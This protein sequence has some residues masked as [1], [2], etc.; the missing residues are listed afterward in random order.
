MTNSKPDFSIV[1]PTFNRA[2]FL[3]VAISSVLKQRNI[4][5]EIIIGDNASTDKTYDIVK[6]FKDRRIKYFRNDKNLGFAENIRKCFKKTS[7]MYIFTLGD[8]DLILDDNTLFFILKVM[9]KTKAGM[10]SIGTIYYSKT[11]KIPSKTFILSNRLIFIK[12]RKNKTLPTKSLSF[13]ISFF[14]GLIYKNSLID[15][16]KITNSF[17]Y[18]YFPFSYDVIQKGGIVYIPDY[19]TV[20]RISLRF[21]P[22]YYSLDKLGSFFME[23]YLNMINQFIFNKDYKEHKKKFLRDGT[24][25]LPSIKLFTDNRNYLKVLQKLINLDRTLLFEPKFIIF[26]LIGLLPKSI[27]ELIRNIAIYILEKKTVNLV[28]KYNYFEKIKK[29]GI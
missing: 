4:S 22:S 9:N 6:S 28:S 10:G 13:N 19:F 26:S 27:L 3:K 12:P 21:V 15:T 29:L 2:R 11:P 23:D 25:L 8:D 20:G 1:I 7:G 5:F 17:N 18:P 14:T 24:I 16:N